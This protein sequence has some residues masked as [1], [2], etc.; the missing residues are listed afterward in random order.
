M[1]QLSRLNLS[2]YEPVNY[3]WSHFVEKFGFD[4]AQKAA[5]QALD[6][7]RMNGDLATLPVLIFE[8]C[9]LALA[10]VELIRRTTGL[11]CCGERMILILSTK[12]SLFQLIRET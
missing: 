10:S 3:L 1:N 8:T 4:K 7:Q 6:L 11:S 9:G 2:E 5:C 12:N